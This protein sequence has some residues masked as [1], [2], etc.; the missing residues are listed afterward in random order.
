MLLS[1]LKFWFSGLLGGWNGIKWPEMTKS[2]VCCT[3]YFRNHI[4]Y[5]LHL[6]GTCFYKMIISPGI[7]F[8][9][10]LHNF[11]F[12]IIRGKIGG[13]GVNG[14]KWPKMTKKFVS[15]T[16][17]L[18]NRTSYDCDFWYTCVKWWYLQQMF[19]FLVFIFS[20]FWFLGFSDVNNEILVDRT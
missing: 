17:Y 4:L 16:P 11:D 19:S 14:K 12:R 1:I 7:F 9:F 10:F 13:Q 2:S 3:L 5:D 20:K 15:L 18:R 8:F 6:W